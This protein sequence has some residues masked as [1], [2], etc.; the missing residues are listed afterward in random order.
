[1]LTLS[2]SIFSGLVIFKMFA[3]I[4]RWQLNPGF[5]SGFEK[6]WAER[7]E[8]IKKEH[9]ALG[10]RLHKSD[11]GSYIAYAQWPSRQAWQDASSTTGIDSNSSQTMKTATKSFEIVAELDVIRD[12]LAQEI[13]T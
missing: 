2:V 3:V 8:E 9:G 12:L 1:M 10:S 7:T 6:A 5:E 4:Y 13:K 11:D